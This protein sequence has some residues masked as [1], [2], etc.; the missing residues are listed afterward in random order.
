MSNDGENISTGMNDQELDKFLKEISGLRVP[1]SPKGKE[2]TWND[3]L[4]AIDQKGKA[5]TRIVRF[6]SKLIWYS[7]AASVA[8]LFAIGV[9]IRQFSTISINVPKGE[10]SSIVLPD[11]SE[12]KINADSRV[13]YKKYGWLNNRIVKL[14]G[15]ALFAVSNGNPFTVDAG[16]GRK[17]TVTGTEFDVFSRTQKFEVKCFKGSVVVETSVVKPIS[18]SK[19]S[20]ISIKENITEPI[21]FELDST[22][23]TT[24]ITGEYYF[25]NSSLSE[26]FEEVQRQFN[27]IITPVGFNPL[28]RNYTGYFKRGI[29]T[30]ALNLVCL[31]MGLSYQISPDS[32]IVT[33]KSE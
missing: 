21:S 29:L 26:V 8:I 7:A 13:E 31:P 3:I 25:T 24:W 10:F 14:D 4:Q 18:I 32:T 1:S 30:E 23:I 16:N 5:E 6:P 17:V 15:E 9:L 19:G 33:I 12:V 20:G 2:Q 27:V 22:H 11:K 28:E